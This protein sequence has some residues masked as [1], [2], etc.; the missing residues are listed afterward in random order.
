MT[1]V[2]PA[3]PAPIR[4]LYDGPLW[5]SIGEQR[6]K[7][8]RCLK[9]HTF[10]YPPGPS[11]PECLSPETE[12]VPISGSGIINSWVVFHRHYL[13]AYPPPYNVIAVRLEEGPLFIS[14]LEGEEP[15]GSWIGHPV[16]LFYQAMPDG[17]IL[18]RFT[19]S[20]LPANSAAR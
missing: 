19:L 8:P 17:F 20:G 9:C 12:W 16:R 4:G 7:L 2:I 10:R 14:N 5:D 3:T 11:C 13:P 15:S 6:M 1:D 18:P